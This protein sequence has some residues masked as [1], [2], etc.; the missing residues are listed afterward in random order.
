MI[1]LLKLLHV[2]GQRHMDIVM[3]GYVYIYLHV[4]V[5]V[6]QLIKN[7]LIF[8]WQVVLL[9]QA[10]HCVHVHVYD[11]QA[12]HTVYNIIWLWYM[13][14]GADICTGTDKDA[15]PRCLSTCVKAY[16]LLNAMF[17]PNS[18]QSSAYRP[19]QSQCSV[20]WLIHFSSSFHGKPSN[21]TRNQKTLGC[22]ETWLFASIAPLP[23]LW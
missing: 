18:F 10:V 19:G 8:L 20:S 13:Y 17:P 1:L 16:L 6:H 5:Q 22:L 9:M 21:H 14:K 2:H 11:L 23:M 15:M 7:L 3:I 12:V 4:H